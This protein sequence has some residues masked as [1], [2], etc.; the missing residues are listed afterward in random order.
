MTKQEL[1]EIIFSSPKPKNWR[2]GQYVFNYIDQV[3]GI[4][5]HIQFKEGIDCFYDDSKIDVF[6]EKAVKIINE[7]Y[8]NSNS[9]S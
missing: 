4:A 3:Y 1:K 6:L 7:Y 2:D 9:R 8:E 5:R